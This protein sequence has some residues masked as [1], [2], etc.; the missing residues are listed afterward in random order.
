VVVRSAYGQPVLQQTTDIT[1]LSPTA[2]NLTRLTVPV[3]A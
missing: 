2:Q 3:P 1:W